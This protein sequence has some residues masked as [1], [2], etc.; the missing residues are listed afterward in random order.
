M[1]CS[2]SSFAVHINVP[3]NAHW[4]HDRVIHAWH[5]SGGRDF[6]NGIVASRDVM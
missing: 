2:N 6:R 5:L 1:N 4:R 3:Y